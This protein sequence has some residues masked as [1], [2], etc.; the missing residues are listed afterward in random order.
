MRK[1]L[2]TYLSIIILILGGIWAFESLKVS[3]E[4]VSSN[5]KFSV[6]RAYALL[7][8]MAQKPH[9]V[10][11][12]E[13]DRV[14]A[15]LVEQ[16]EALGF[17]VEIQTAIGWREKAGVATQAMNIVARRTVDK[18]AKTLV[19]MSHYDSATHSA[20]GASDA[21]SGVVTIL[22][23]LRAFF[24]SGQAYT[25]NLMVLF[26]D[27]EEIGLLGAEAFISQSGVD[28]GN[29]G[30][31][32]NFEA[33]GSGG[34]PYMFMETNYGNQNLISSFQDSEVSVPVAN[35]LMYSIYKMLPND[36]DLT[37]IR[38]HGDIDGFNIAFIGDHFD[39]H[40]AQDIPSR[41]DRETLAHLGDYLMGMLNHYASADLK[42]LRS[43]SD[44]VYFNF[45][46]FKMISYP[47]S[48][49]WVYAGLFYF[50]FLLITLMGLARGRL[51][52]PLIMMGFIPFFLSILLNVLIGV[53]GWKI[54]R[55]IYPQYQD[56]LH[57]F[58]YNG[59]WY[60]AAFATLSLGISLWIYHFFFRLKYTAN[61][62]VAPIFTWL[63]LSIALMVFLPG[64]GFLIFP[65]LFSLIMFFM[66]V[67]KDL[68]KAKL[69]LTFSVLAI[70]S[71]LILLPLV[72]M[73]PVGLGLGML[74][75][76]N[77]VVVALFGLNIAYFA[78][79]TKVKRGVY[80]TVALSV[81]L[82]LMAHVKSGYDLE[83][84]QPSSLNYVQ[85]LVMEK[86]FWE[87]YDRETNVYN[88]QKIKQAKP[89][90]HLEAMPGNGKYRT[91]IR[92]HQEAES[93]KL[94]LA[95]TQL[96]IDSLGWTR[97]DYK[98]ARPIHRLEIRS[99]EAMSL[100]SMKIG[101][102]ISGEHRVLKK[103]DRLLLYLM[104]DPLDS[105]NLAWKASGTHEMGLE[106]QESS[107]D[108]PNNPWMVLEPRP[109]QMMPTPFVLNDAIISRYIIEM[110]E[111]NH[112]DES[113]VDPILN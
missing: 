58:T 32:I 50:A 45:P 68:R 97:L 99:R 76:S 87:S 77:F 90:N 81:A 73:F 55:N 39:Y 63:M 11:S 8:Q 21:G 92:M 70:P 112:T 93:Y 110:Q 88:A 75:L 82:F 14:R 102:R 6:D 4:P 61:F 86:S 57:G 44:D 54:L 51:K 40:T 22:E 7:E 41:L 101:A 74:A 109:A 43:S 94:P 60:I 79:I 48:W 28:L 107:Y 113:V 80:A 89:G 29:L 96:Y 27:A 108:L 3:T 67:F 111:K 2:Y 17:E 46:L 83:H 56:I 98:P 36:T 31:F 20:V 69:R 47:F 9:Y 66:V 38:E 65:A 71:L 91:S 25:N 18:N 104:S 19:L 16:L 85:D 34:R 10:G 103:G 106:I 59:Y 26:T 30:L 33:R 49:N 105:I 1:E 100:D 78:V 42:A 15:Y 23:G 72:R 95:D 62:V 12:K 52:V 13:H 53:L 64:G 35:S 24:N 37:V 84:K 5:S